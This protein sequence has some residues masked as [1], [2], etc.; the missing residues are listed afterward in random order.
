MAK[1]IFQNW[2]DRVADH[3]FADDFASWAS[4]WSQPLLIV[5]PCGNSVITSEEMLHEKF[6]Q[7][8]TLFAIQRVTDMIRMAHDVS[9]MTADMITGSYTTEI[10]SHGQ[11]VVPRFESTMILARRDNVWRGTELKSGMTVPH[12]HLIHS[13]T[14]REV[15]TPSDPAPHNIIQ[16]RIP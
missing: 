4:A 9:F 7:W 5:S 16:G 6:V 2:L 12:R 11:R 1:I 13:N 10:L 3:V 8:R 14:P 15:P